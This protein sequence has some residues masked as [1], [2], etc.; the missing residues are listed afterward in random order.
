[1][2]DSIMENLF[3]DS[4]S[5]QIPKHVAII[6]DGNGRWAK[7]HMMPRN[8][9]HVQGSKTVENIC[10][11]AYNMGVEY[12]TV[13]AFSTENWKRP[14]EEVDALMKLLRSYLKNCQKTSSKNNMKV[15]VLGELDGLNKDIQD[16]VIELEKVSAANTGLNFQ[17]A[18]NYGGRDEILRAAKRLAEDYKS[19]KVNLDSI[20]ADDFS[21]YLDTRGIPDPDLMIRTSGEK[22]IS[23]FLLWQ[24]AYTEFYFTDTL[25]PDF[26][27]AELRKAIEYY[28]NRKRNFGG[29][30]ED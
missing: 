11:E 14:K 23:N 18:L 25:W 24:L 26:N 1:M 17:V 30:K 12:L 29:I 28:G 27:K 16:S 19:G 21:G 10:E 9:G 2:G 3:G 20:K 15:R 5:K 6:L 22:R 13:Y 8:Y 7:K 4:S